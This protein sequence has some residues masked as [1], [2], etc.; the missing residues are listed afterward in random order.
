MDDGVK[1]ANPMKNFALFPAC[2]A[3]LFVTTLGALSAR[4]ADAPAAGAERVFELRVYHANPGKLDA[5]NA[6][7]RDHT[8]KLFEKHGITIIAF[9]TPTDGDKAKNTLIY[10][11]G[12]PSRDAA[13]KSWNDFKEDS[14]WKTARAESEKDGALVDRVES[15]YMKPTDYSPIK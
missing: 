1:G 13:T 2:V 4:A 7:F 5:L 14:D 3:A 10:V 6:R 9:W 15:T 11:L 8:N 12:Y